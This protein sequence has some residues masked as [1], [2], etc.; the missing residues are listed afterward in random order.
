MKRILVKGLKKEIDGKKE[1]KVKSKKELKFIELLE[2][3]DKIKLWGYEKIKIKYYNP[4]TKKFHNYIVD[5]VVKMK[6]GEIKLYEIKSKVEKYKNKEIEYRLKNL[7][8]IKILNSLKQGIK[9]E[10]IEL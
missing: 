5:F 6:N 4:Y 9:I 10:L 8:K 7:S 2:K 1:I 3:N